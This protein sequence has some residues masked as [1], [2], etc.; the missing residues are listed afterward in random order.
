MVNLFLIRTFGFE[1][2]FGFEAGFE[3]T[4]GFETTLLVYVNLIL[5]LLSSSLFGD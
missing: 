2:T 3:T 5:P 4:F 1:T